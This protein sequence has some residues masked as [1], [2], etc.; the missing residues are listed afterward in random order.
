LPL[1]VGLLFLTLNYFSSSINRR[2]IRPVYNDFGA[3]GHGTRLIHIL[4]HGFGAQGSLFSNWDILY[5]SIHSYISIWRILC[6][7]H[8][9]SY[10]LSVVLNATW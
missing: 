3:V 1:F 10:R 2:N 8:P 6:L 9:E 7:R 4:P 5:V